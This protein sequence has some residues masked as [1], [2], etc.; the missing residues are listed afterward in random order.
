M[1]KPRQ[2]FFT[3]QDIVLYSPSTQLDVVIAPNNIQ[4]TQ[5]G[6]TTEKLLH[7]T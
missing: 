5:Q 6:K 7:S 4:P 3:Q 2:H 1:K